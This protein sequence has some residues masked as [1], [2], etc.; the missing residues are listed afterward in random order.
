M[1]KLNF[2][3]KPFNLNPCYTQAE[4]MYSWGWIDKHDLA[5]DVAQGTLPASEY[6]RITGDKYEVSEGTTK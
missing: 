5:N 3:F 4:K 1:L 2:T 6:E